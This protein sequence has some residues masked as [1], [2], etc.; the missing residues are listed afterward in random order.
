MNELSRARVVLSVGL[1]TLLF[2]VALYLAGRLSIWLSTGVAA[3]LSLLLAWLCAGRRLCPLLAPDTR[4]VL[5]GVAGG[6]LMIA[7]THA[8]YA[9]ATRLLPAI[10]AETKAL[11]A[12]LDQPPGPIWALPVLVLVVFAEEVVWRG[13]LHDGLQRAMNRPRSV[14]LGAALYA[15]PQ[16]V[17]QSVL[18]P[19]VAL[20]CG[21]I[22]GYQRTRSVSLVPVFLTHL[23]WDLGVFFL[24][25]LPVR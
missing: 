4:Q 19:V 23:V 12:L 6:L 18:L 5:L 24:L 20:G 9:V 17:G 2:G 1:S 16:L 21:M 8:V 14:L 11:Y 10:V 3:A 22:W 7:V 15:L 13:L 25:P